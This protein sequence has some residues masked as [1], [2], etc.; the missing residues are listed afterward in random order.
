MILYTQ[1]S[2][3]YK[4][5]VEDCCCDYETVDNL[6][7]EVLNPLL[8]DLV[9]TPFFRYFK[10]KLWCDCPFWPDDGMCRLRDCSVC[11]CPE[12]E[13]PEPFKRPYNIAGLPSDNLI[14]QEGKPQAAVDRT[15]DNIAFRGWVETNNPWTHED[16]TD[17]GNVV[18]NQ[19]RLMHPM[20]M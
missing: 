15:I 2:G 17:N 18:L 20:Y 6:N 1:G 19:N 5:I 11:E 16:D 8:Q 12:N 7:S 3:K 14:C 9:A 10:V 4:G 13:F